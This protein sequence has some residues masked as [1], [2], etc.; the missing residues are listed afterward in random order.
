MKLIR[1]K[2]QKKIDGDEQYI[3]LAEDIQ[4]NFVAMYNG[5]EKLNRVASKITDIS[6]LM[7]L[8]PEDPKV[9][10]QI[11]EKDRT[12]R[13]IS[14]N[15]SGGQGRMSLYAFEKALER[16]KSITDKFSRSETQLI[17]VL[18]WSGESGKINRELWK[19]S[20]NAIPGR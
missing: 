4:K 20:P 13:E 14:H 5:L 2:K 17:N 12:L 11:D 6:K 15:F 10:E 3:K 1:V 7:K 18:T 9:Y 19:G 8:D 16:F